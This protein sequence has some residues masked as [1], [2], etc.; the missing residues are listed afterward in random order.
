MKV[1]GFRRRDELGRIHS[2]KDMAAITEL[3]KAKGNHGL[4]MLVAK[5]P[6][7]TRGCP[8]A[9][10]Y[11]FKAEIEGLETWRNNRDNEDRGFERKFPTHVTTGPR[12]GNAG[13]S[14]Q[15]ASERP[16]NSN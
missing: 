6:G 8:A 7:S 5:G 16:R 1:L 12:G 4:G 2:S 9:G 10:I 11:S 15:Q 13:N 3:K 14:W